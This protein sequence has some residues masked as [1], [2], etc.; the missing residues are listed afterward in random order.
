MWFHFVFY[1][2]LRKAYNVHSFIQQIFIKNLLFLGTVLGIESWL[3][4]HCP[5]GERESVCVHACE[6][7]HIW[8]FVT[9]WTIAHKAPLSMESS[10]QENWSG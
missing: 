2:F 9:S 4:N 6:L 5:Y 1:H 7:S 8:L 10:R 3:W